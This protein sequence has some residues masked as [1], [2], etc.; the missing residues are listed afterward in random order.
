MSASV[1]EIVTSSSTGS[2]V[3]M[4][5]PRRSET[6]NP[7]SV[8]TAPFT[9]RIFP[10]ASRTNSASAIVSRISRAARAAVIGWKRCRRMEPQAMS[11]NAMTG[12]YPI[13]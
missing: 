8:V 10:S 11:M 9:T 3:S 5:R 1:R 4:L 12:M 2:S 13:G 6:P 7:R